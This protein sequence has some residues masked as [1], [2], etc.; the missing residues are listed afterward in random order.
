M[1]N[2]S[3]SNILVLVELR[4][5]AHTKCCSGACPPPIVLLR[6]LSLQEGWEPPAG[7]LFLQEALRMGK[8]DTS[9]V[10]LQNIYC[11]I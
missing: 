9:T 8:K 7:L 1:Y 10:L 6:L 4:P 5:E 2:N 11:V 3:N